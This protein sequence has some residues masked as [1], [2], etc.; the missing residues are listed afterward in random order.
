MR[1]ISL[2]ILKG[3][4]QASKTGTTSKNKLDLVCV[5]VMK[6]G[7]TWFSKIKGALNYRLIGIRVIGSAF[8]R[9]TLHFA[10]HVA[11][12][13]SFLGIITSYTFNV[14][15]ICVTTLTRLT[16]TSSL[17]RKGQHIKR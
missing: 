9:R 4:T 13:R 17:C 3:T 15:K 7:L 6:E 8:G 16:S 5:I 10:E 1:S 2:L 12:S 11:C 14:S